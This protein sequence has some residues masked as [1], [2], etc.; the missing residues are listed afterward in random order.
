MWSIVHWKIIYKYSDKT[1]IWCEDLFNSTF[2]FCSFINSPVVLYFPQLW[3]EKNNNM[4][5]RLTLVEFQCNSSSLKWSSLYRLVWQLKYDLL[6]NVQFFLLLCK[7]CWTVFSKILSYRIYLIQ[8]IDS[9]LQ[10]GFQFGKSYYFLTLIY[11][12]WLFYET[13]FICCINRIFWQI[14]SI[15]DVTT[16]V[17]ISVP[18]WW[19]QCLSNLKSNLYLYRFLYFRLSYP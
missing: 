9:R 12:L 16:S 5:N 19:N 4:L 11:Y 14:V 7:D 2:H 13:S 15:M 1:S 6:R 10:S 8:K 18:M 17:R 3:K